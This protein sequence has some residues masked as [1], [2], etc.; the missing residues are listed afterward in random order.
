MHL[1]GH[2]LADY[3]ARAVEEFEP[4]IIWDRGFLQSRKASYAAV[5][6]PR[7]CRAAH[8]LDEFM[9]SEPLTTDIPAFTRE[10][11]IASGEKKA[12]FGWDPPRR[13]RSFR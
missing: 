9:Q 3:T 6:S 1:D 13:A 8:D 2:R 10:I 12:G 7:A 4:N 11:E 5:G